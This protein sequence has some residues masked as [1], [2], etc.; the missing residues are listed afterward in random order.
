M[1][2]FC[3]KNNFRYGPVK[4]NFQ[5]DVA[6]TEL[7]SELSSEDFMQVL[8]DHVSKEHRG[9]TSADPMPDAVQRPA[10]E[11]STA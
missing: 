2:Y 10:H 5:D 4:Q 11:E 8:H 6:A 1:D 3:T 7:D 9:V